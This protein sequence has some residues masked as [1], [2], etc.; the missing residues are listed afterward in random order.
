VDVHHGGGLHVIYA[1]LRTFSVVDGAQ[2]LRGQ[3]LGVMGNAG[4]SLGDH[5]HYQVKIDGTNLDPG[6]PKTCGILAALWTTCP[7]SHTPPG[8]DVCP[9]GADPC[10]SVSGDVDCDSNVNSLDALR[11][12]RGTAGLP[13]PGACFAASA[14]VNCSGVV[15]AIDALLVLRHAAGLPVALPQDCPPIGGYIGFP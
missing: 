9:F 3:E 2:V 13:Q 5:L 10:V 14:D 8:G 12:L 6:N 1:H 7:A 11:V 15:T 4:C